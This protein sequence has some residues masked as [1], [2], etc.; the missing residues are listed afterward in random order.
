M[1]FQNICFHNVEQMIPF[2]DG[3]KMARLPENVMNCVNEGIRS[4]TGTFSS[5]VE[6]RMRLKGEKAV[7]RLRA[8]PIEEAQV[9]FV[10]Y[11]SFQG[12]WQVSS[13]V[14]GTESTCVSLVPP[15]EPARLRELTQEGGLPFCPDL[16][17]LVLPYGTCVFLGVDG[18]VEPPRPGDEPGITYLAYGSS[19]THGSL[20]LDTPHTYPFRIAQELKCDYLNLGFAGTAHLE[21][22]MAEYI[23]ARRDWDFASVEMGVNM[24][25]TFSEEAFEQRV[26]DFTRILADDGRPVFATSM[27]RMGHESEK[28]EHFRDIVRKYAGERLI[29]TEGTDLLGQPW[30]VSADLVHPSIQGVEGIARKW[31]DI[32]RRHLKT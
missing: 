19:I 32:M 27:F 13:F 23:V 31:S 30:D 24:L 12:G 6:L 1:I 8:L 9:G 18:E 20:A 11:G 16:I 14:I 21:K 17:R 7:V 4:R 29:F 22:E 26:N 10:Y 2:E 5:G 25:G 3:W 15:A 28:A